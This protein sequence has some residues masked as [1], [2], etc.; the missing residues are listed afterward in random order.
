LFTLANQPN[1]LSHVPEGTQKKDGKINF[2]IRKNKVKVKV[3]KKKK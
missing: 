3:K 2:K 1:E